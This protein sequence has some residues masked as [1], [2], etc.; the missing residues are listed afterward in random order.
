VCVDAM[1]TRERTSRPS[2]GATYRRVWSIL[3]VGAARRICAAAGARSL[4]AGA[5]R[6]P[7]RTALV[8]SLERRLVPHAPPSKPLFEIRGA[9]AHC[10]G[11]QTQIWG[12]YASS[13]PT[14]NGSS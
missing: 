13:P 7:R 10:A 1:L 12:P 2:G 6:M 9:I 5:L 3:H 8:P 11:R 14:F 4:L